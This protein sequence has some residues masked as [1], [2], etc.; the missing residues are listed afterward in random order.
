MLTS[1]FS[2]GLLEVDEVNGVADVICFG[3]GSSVSLFCC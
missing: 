1:V 3:D 2:I